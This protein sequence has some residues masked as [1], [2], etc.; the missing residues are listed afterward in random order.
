[1]SYCDGCNKEYKVVVQ[2]DG[3]EETA[4]RLDL[5]V[6]YCPF[7]GENLERAHNH[8][9]GFDNEEQVELDF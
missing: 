5:Q 2:M 3:Y 4:H 1:M 7:C 9:N 6:E 8:V